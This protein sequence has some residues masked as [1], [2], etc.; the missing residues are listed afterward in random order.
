MVSAIR[1]GLR[2]QRSPSSIS[3]KRGL[4]R[5]AVE[6]QVHL[7]PALYEAL[8]MSVEEV[9]LRQVCAGHTRQPRFSADGTIEVAVRGA[10]QA[11]RTQNLSMHHVHSFHRF[12][13]A[14]K[15]K[16]LQV[17]FR[18]PPASGNSTGP[19]VDSSWQRH[20]FEASAGVD[21]I[22]NTSVLRPKLRFVQD[23]HPVPLHECP[24]RCV[25]LGGLHLQC[26]LAKLAA[27]K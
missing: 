3:N 19:A 14:N 24:K 23:L 15:I 10:C 18:A 27:G 1:A 7:Q 8:P 25:N 12:P 4:R 17:D 6:R 5:I 26:L 21:L 22:A 11:A 20:V 16:S 13:K 2:A 9:D